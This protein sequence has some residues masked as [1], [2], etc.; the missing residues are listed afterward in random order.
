MYIW[1]MTDPIEDATPQW[2][3]RLHYLPL[4]TSS[5]PLLFAVMTRPEGYV[6]LQT[7]FPKL[8]LVNAVQGAPQEA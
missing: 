6:A 5:T 3:A 8:R 7:P 1:Y 4:E 2:V